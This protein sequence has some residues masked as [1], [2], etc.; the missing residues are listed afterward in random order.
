MILIILG[1]CISIAFTLKYRSTQKSITLT[2]IKHLLKEYPFLFTPADVG[3][4]NTKTLAE[5]R[6]TLAKYKDLTEFY[7]YLQSYDSNV[8]RDPDL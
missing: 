2:E 7:D 3:K 8:P 4:L 1:L 5:L 6:F